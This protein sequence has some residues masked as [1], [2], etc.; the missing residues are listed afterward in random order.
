MLTSMRKGIGSWSVKIFLGLLVASF[1]VWG[2][3]DVFRNV[4]GNNVAEVGEIEITPTE[5]LYSFRSQIKRFEANTG[6]QLD[7]E[8]AISLG[9][10]RSVLSQLIGRAALDQFA[11]DGGLETSDEQLRRTIRQS[12]AFQDQLGNFDRFLFEN[13]LQQNGMSESR[14]LSMLKSDLSRGALLD[15]V[16]INLEPPH[17]LAAQLYRYRL[18][19]RTAELIFIPAGWGA[20]IVREPDAAALETFHQDNAARFSAPEYRDISF[21]NLR[22]EQL[23]DRVSADEQELRDYYDQRIDEFSSLETREIQQIILPDTELAGRAKDRL[24]SGENFAAIALELAELEGDDISLGRLNRND[25]AIEKFSEDLFNA[26]QGD[27]VGPLES[28]FGWHIFRIAS[29]TP[30][31][32]RSYTEVKKSIEKDLLLER[33]SEELYRLT[34]EVE[35]EL[36]GGASLSEAAAAA[37][38]HY[39]PDR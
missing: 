18:E 30:E 21:L 10:D 6:V 34:T 7:N 12:P 26:A 28:D 33:A 3:G 16:A 8:R 9:F 20:D 29:I 25:P 5:F 24:A 1:A 27:I 22:P 4:G 17:E 32:I 39:E 38:E 11:I 23:I 36:G 15:S 35:D 31:K 37:V 13:V 2:I 19:A 14:Y